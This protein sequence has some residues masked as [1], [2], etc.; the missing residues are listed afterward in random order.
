[1]LKAS[2]HSIHRCEREQLTFSFLIRVYGYGLNLNQP[3]GIH[4]T[5][6]SHGGTRRLNRILLRIKELGVC[7]KPAGIIK[8]PV[9]RCIRGQVYSQIDDILHRQSLLLQLLL[10]FLQD[11]DPLGFRIP[12]AFIHRFAVL[13]QQWRNRPAR[14]EIRGTLRH[15][16]PAG[17]RGCR[18][19]VKFGG[20]QS[21]GRL[22]MGRSTV[23]ICGYAYGTE[24]HGECQERL[25]FIFHG[26]WT[27]FSIM[28][29]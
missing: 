23:G 3:I 18:T 29:S 4:K 22:L 11:A 14:I 17:D 19:A 12:I 26:L 25:Q 28:I 2:G 9:L 24:Q 8:G 1:M 20:R 27:P 7:V 5:G 6:N 10:D 13:V 16:Y 15:D 21:F